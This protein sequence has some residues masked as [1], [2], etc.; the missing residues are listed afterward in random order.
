MLVVLAF[1][2]LAFALASVPP[3]ES[4]YKVSTEGFTID[5]HFFLWQE[6]YDFY[7]KK[8]LDMDVLHIRTEAFIPGELFVPLN[9]K[10]TEEQVKS[11]MARFLPFREIVQQTFMEKSGDWLS[12]N[13]PLENA[14][15]APQPKPKVAR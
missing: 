15:P 11:A 7:F 4:E 2:F 5:E 12:R 14:A 9:G 1:V 10:V 13:F 6:L 8:R 3:H